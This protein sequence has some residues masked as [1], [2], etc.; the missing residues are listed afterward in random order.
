M[1]DGSCSSEGLLLV[2][3]ARVARNRVGIR[4]REIEAASGQREKGDLA[5]SKSLEHLGLAR[6]RVGFLTVSARPYKLRPSE[7]SRS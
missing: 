2:N 3:L 4:C 5:S 7:Q 1:Q 6:S